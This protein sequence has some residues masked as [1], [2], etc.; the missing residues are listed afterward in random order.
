MKRRHPKRTITRDVRTRRP[1]HPGRGADEREAEGWPEGLRVGDHM[2]RSV[3]TIQSSALVRGAGEMMK[4][5]KIRHLPVVDQEG[6]LV[7]IVTDRDLR[8]VV[9]DP[10]LLGR[11]PDL[12]RAL[13]TMTVGEVMTVGVITARPGTDLRQAA[14]LM[15]ERK[16]GALPVVEGDRVVGILTESDV[17]KAFIGIIGAGVLARPYRWALAA[18]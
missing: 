1:I 18:R 6:G 5:R 16:I 3:T 14:G 9:F 4:T 2:T 11:A 13:D 12:A 8:H 10:A 17:L 7:G 15:H